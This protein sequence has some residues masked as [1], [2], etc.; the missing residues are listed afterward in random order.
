MH[1]CEHNSFHWWYYVGDGLFF[2]SKLTSGFQQFL[3][4]IHEKS[5][6]R[7][8]CSQKVWFI[9]GTRPKCKL[10]FRKS[11]GTQWNNEADVLEDEIDEE[12]SMDPRDNADDDDFIIV[13]SS[14]PSSPFARL[15]GATEAAGPSSSGLHPSSSS[16]EPQRT[17]QLKEVSSPSSPY[18]KHASPVREWPSPLVR[19]KSKTLK[20]VSSK[21][22]RQRAGAAPRGSAKARMAQYLYNPPLPARDGPEPEAEPAVARTSSPAS[23]VAQESREAAAPLPVVELSS[24]VQVTTGADVSA[25][26]ARMAEQEEMLDSS[27]LDRPVADPFPGASQFRFSFPGN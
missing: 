23:P 7:I 5:G 9:R 8:Q 16:A 14:P 26:E 25:P 27:I 13:E 15:D 22:P 24:P 4:L 10:Q 11:N 2:F 3:K 17:R 12:F 20:N 21:A 1:R 19:Y 6:L 18:S